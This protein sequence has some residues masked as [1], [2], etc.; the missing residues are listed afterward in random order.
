[1]KKKLGM[2]LVYLMTG[3]MIVAFV[4]LA[5]AVLI[6]VGVVVLG[7]LSAG[8]SFTWSQVSL[9]PSAIVQEILAY[10]IFALIVSATVASFVAVGLKATPFAANLLQN[11]LTELK[12]QEGEAI[13]G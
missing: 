2:G 11:I 9:V 3:G 8:V 13:G 10:V 6:G 12:R 4:G 5:L 1:M 7:V